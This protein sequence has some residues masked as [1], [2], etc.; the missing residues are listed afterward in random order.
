MLAAAVLLAA[1]AASAE[2]GEPSAGGR[3]SGTTISLQAG[4]TSGSMDRAGQALGATI[5]QELGSRW[6]LE[7]SAA[8]LAEGRGANAL[9]ADA[10]VLFHLRPTRE[11]AAP[12]L[13]LGGGVYRTSFDMG[14]GRMRDGAW[15][16]GMPG[17]GGT[18]GGPYGPGPHG[19]AGAQPGGNPYGRMP[20]FYSQRMGGD[21]DPPR[22]Q[23]ERSFTDPAFSAGAGVRIDL[24]SGMFLR[25]DGRVLVA[26]DGGDSFTVGLATVS[27]GW[28]F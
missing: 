10:S 9:R 28:R 2:E 24:G 14:G 17:A 26:I 13:A 16:G 4:L 5:V 3:G 1:V 12:Y 20:R 15:Q 11:R 27:F 7:G 19:P 22:W 18:M 6:A 25:P 21:P 8:Y 23:G